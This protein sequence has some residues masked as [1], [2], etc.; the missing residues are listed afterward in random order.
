LPASLNRFTRSLLLIVAA[1][2]LIAIYIN[3]FNSG[4]GHSHTL[5]VPFTFA[6][7][8][9]Q[10]AVSVIFVAI[11]IAL[12]AAFISLLLRGPPEF[13]SRGSKNVNV[14]NPNYALIAMLAF[15]AVVALAVLFL[16]PHFL[17]PRPFTGKINSTNI[18]QTSSTGN[19]PGATVIR[20]VAASFLLL[21]IAITA[22]VLLL[23]AVALFSVFRTRQTNYRG[24]REEMGREVQ[25]AISTAMATGDVRRAIMDAYTKMV[26]LLQRAGVLNREWYTPREF[27]EEASRILGFRVQTVHELTLLYEEAHYSTHE[28]GG[29]DMERAMSLLERMKLELSG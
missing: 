16:H 8:S 3:S 21:F 4:L 25:E 2:F 14:S 27:E 28:L 15:I 11:F 1:I 18:T 22:T 26:S 23:L 17:F 7:Y 10:I 19:S 6:S 5:N 20:T 29:K 24:F 12:L 9:L 13:G